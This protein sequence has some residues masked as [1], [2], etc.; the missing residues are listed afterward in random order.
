M[1]L[2]TLNA[3]YILSITYYYSL[4]KS[5]NKFKNFG[6]QIEHSKYLA[7]ENLIVINCK[8]LILDKKF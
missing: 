8:F 3:L 6:L 5:F 4:H 2:E 1:L 7:F